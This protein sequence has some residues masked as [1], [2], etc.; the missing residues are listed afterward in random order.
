MGVVVKKFSRRSLAAGR[1]IALEGEA[2][3]Q[4]RHAAPGWHFGLWRW[5]YR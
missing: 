2:G 4:A 3:Y 5:Q 1:L